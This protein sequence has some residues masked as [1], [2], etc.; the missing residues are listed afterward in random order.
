MPELVGHRGKVRQEVRGQGWRGKDAGAVGPSGAAHVGNN[1]GAVTGSGEV[2][3]L[4]AE[5]KEESGLW[6]VGRRRCSPVHIQGWSVCLML[7][8]PGPCSPYQ[9]W[10][11][12]H[13]QGGY[14]PAESCLSL[15][16]SELPAEPCPWFCSQNPRVWRRQSTWTHTQAGHKLPH[17]QRPKEGSLMCP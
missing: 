16:A 2:P 5:A 1:S 9:H 15:R 8:Q 14:C 4:L 12:S 13:W 6:L 7:P 17:S 3:L 10:G 11:P